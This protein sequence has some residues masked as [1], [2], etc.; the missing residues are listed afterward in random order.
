M[1]FPAAS[2][3]GCGSTR[4]PAAASNVVLD[5]GV[6]DP[7]PGVDDRWASIV[8]DEPR[9]REVIEILDEA[10]VGAGGVRP[11]EP[12]PHGIRFEDVPRAMADAAARMEMAILHAEHLD[13]AFDLE[14]V[15][16]GGRS[17]TATVRWGRRGPSAAIRYRVPGGDADAAQASLLAAVET[18][19]ESWRRSDARSMEAWADDVGRTLAEQGAIVS[20][21]SFVPERHRFTLLMLDEAEARIEVRRMPPPQVLDWTAE[22]GMFPRPELAARLGRTFMEMLREWGRTPAWSPTPNRPGRSSS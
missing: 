1:L 5:A 8:L 22:A 16:R 18:C 10:A 11:L 12:A 7:V 15:D 6:E 9:R 17:A 19:L 20:T 14:F 21:R 13:R 4:P 2:S 3:G